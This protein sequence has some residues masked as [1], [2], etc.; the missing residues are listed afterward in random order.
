MSKTYLE[1]YLTKHPDAELIYGYPVDEQS[2]QRF[3][4]C[5]KQAGYQTEC[6]MG[7]HPDCRDC[8]NSTMS[9]SSEKRLARNCRFGEEYNGPPGKTI[10]GCT[11]ANIWCN[12]CVAASCKRYADKTM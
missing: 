8:W 6:I 12:D 4:L 5:V 2:E 7:D 11:E 3:V 10:I 9:E 1:D